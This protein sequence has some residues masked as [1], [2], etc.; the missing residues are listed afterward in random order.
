MSNELKSDEGVTYSYFACDWLANMEQLRSGKMVELIKAGLGLNIELRVDFVP[1]PQ[2]F[3]VIRFVAR[4]E[5]RESFAKFVPQADECWGLR[6]WFSVS[7]EYYREISQFRSY[8]HKTLEEFW[9]GDVGQANLGK[10]VETWLAKASGNENLGDLLNSNTAT[11][12]A[13]DYLPKNNVSEFW[14]LRLMSVFAPWGVGREIR[15]TAVKTNE[16]GFYIQGF[17]F[18]VFSEDE[19]KRVLDETKAENFI[20]CVPASEDDFLN[21]TWLKPWHH[22]KYEQELNDL[23]RKNL[24]I[25]NL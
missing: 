2:G 5:N 18:R 3:F 19:L 16:Q 9:H 11:Y 15:K 13:Y 23:A 20:A 4:V 24:E 12:W 22:D 10:L 14:I 17:V 8:A 21:A 7:E 1:T 25:G 6:N